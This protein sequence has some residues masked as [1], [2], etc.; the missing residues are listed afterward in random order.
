[1]VLECWVILIILGTVGYMIVRS[2]RKMWALGVLPLMLVPVLNIIYGP[3][4]E[5]LVH[6][7]PGLTHLT[8]VI[9][10][11]IYIVAF[12]AASCLVFVFAHRLPKGRS[13][14]AYIV[15]SILFTAILIIIFIIKV[16]RL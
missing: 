9:R 11:I 6:V 12:L 14:Y 8:N 16:V 13:K 2:N 4:A 10:L 5:H 7:D 3:I 1:M 15:S